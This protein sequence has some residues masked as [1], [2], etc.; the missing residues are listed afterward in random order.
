MIETACPKCKGRFKEFTLR[1]TD[2]LIDMCQVCHAVWFDKEEFWTV[3]KNKPAQ[4]QFKKQGLLNKTKTH[5]QCPKCR[6]PHAI[7]EKGLL[8]MTQI[9]VE[10]CLLCESFLF[11]DGEYRQAKVQ[12]KENSVNVKNNLSLQ[13]NT[14]N[15]QN[16]Q[17][18]KLQQ[19]Q[20]IRSA[21][22]FFKK[23]DASKNLDSFPSPHPQKNNYSQLL[24]SKSD[25]EAVKRN[26]FSIKLFR[27]RLKNLKNDVQEFTGSIDKPPALESITGFFSRINRAFTLIQKEP[28]ILFFSF[29]QVLGICI[30]YLIWIQMLNWIPAEVWESARETE[31]N[32]P[33]DLVLIAWAFVCVGLASLPIGFFTACIGAVSLL[34]IQGKESTV[35]KC[36][37]YVFPKIW[38]LWIFSWIDGWITVNRIAERLPVGGKKKTVAQKML[39]EAIY[40]AWKL[41][42]AGMIPSLLSSKNSWRA[43]KNSFGFLKYKTWDIIKLRLGYSLVNWIIGVGAYVVSFAYIDSHVDFIQNQQELPARIHSFFLLVGVPL[44]ISIAILK[45]FVRPL[46]I[47][48]LFDIY[49]EYMIA[50]KQKITSPKQT[51]FA[52]TALWFFIILI[53]G[54]VI[55]FLFRDNLGVTEKLS[56]PYN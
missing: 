39:E 23:E 47:I 54:I 12:I 36:C 9:E 56:T 2:V 35:L 33:A 8:P 28:E 51:P 53:T 52:Q 27:K 41:G 7:L 50:T 37:K 20:D 49:S 22:S 42:T 15:H 55:V 19:N 44:F 38:P 25:L 3:L 45:M 29:L 14:E 32:S 43:C 21:S 31:G 30:A 5:Y 16:S 24:F 34:N 10:H 48:S 1:G 40:Y 11:D 6:S 18:M 26:D 4:N 46:Y 17:K 13:E